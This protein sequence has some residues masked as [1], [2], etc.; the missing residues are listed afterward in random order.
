MPYRR[1]EKG[2]LR[3]DGKPGFRTPTGKI[4]LYCTTFENY[5]LDPL[6]YH[7]EPIESPV[8]TPDI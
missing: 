8:S 7:R 3:P 1:Y 5:G 6:P 4:E 2:Q